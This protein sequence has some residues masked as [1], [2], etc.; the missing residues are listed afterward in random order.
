MYEVRFSCSNC[1]SFFVIDV[2]NFREIWEVYILNDQYCKKIKRTVDEREEYAH[3][4]EDIRQTKSK[5]TRYRVSGE[6]KDLNR[7]K[8]VV[9]IHATAQLQVVI[10]KPERFAEET[11]AVADELTASHTVVLNLEETDK[12][13][14]RRILDFVSGVAYANGGKIKRIATNT[15][16]IT[17]YNVDLTGENLVDELESNGVYF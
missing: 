12:D 10:C 14:S 15:Y 5:S 3:D 17:P 4:I 9:N 6:S 2:I 13:A 11:R 7:D 1:F 8:K 16:I